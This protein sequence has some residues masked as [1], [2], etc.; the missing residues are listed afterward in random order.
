M[1]ARS[2]RDSFLSGDV[3]ASRG[4]RLSVLALPLVAFFVAASPMAASAQWSTDPALNLSVAQGAGEQILPKV[5]PTADGGCY[6]SWYDGGSGYDVRVQRLD[7]GGNPQ[8]GA[9]GVLVADR[10]FSSVQDYALDIDAAGNALLVFRDD[11][12]GG[13]Q[14]TAASIGSDGTPLWGANGIQ[15]TST[16]DFVAAPKIA[17]TTDGGAVVAWT[18]D[19]TTRVQ[20]LDSIGGTVWGADVVLTP[21]AGSYSASD[22]HGAGDGAILSFVHQTGGF[23][24]PRHIIAQKFDG[25][26]G[27]LWGAGH[28]SVFDSGSVQFGN[29]PTFVTDGSGGAVFSW[30]DAGS[31]QLQCGVQRVLADGTE[32]FPHNG[33]VV[34]TVASRV[35]VN[36]SAAFA[37]GSEEIFVFWKEQTSNQAQ[38]GVFGQK[39]DA[40]GTR[41]WT[42]NGVQVLGLSTSDVGSIETW[43]VGSGAMVFWDQAPAF[44]Q[45]RLYGARLSGDGVIDVPPFDVASTP[46]GKSRLQVRGSTSGFAI[47]AW[48]DQRVD[49]GDVY[50]QSVQPDGSLGVDPTSAPEVGLSAG[51]SFASPNPSRGEVMVSFAAVAGSG[52]AGAA[53]GSSAARTAAVFD[54]HGRSVRGGLTVSDRGESIWDGRDGAGRE[55]VPGVYY[56]RVVDGAEAV[57]VTIVR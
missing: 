1:S 12:F 16:S 9:N 47:L 48:Q 32:A 27:L 46:S 34:S 13:T 41:Q 28:V 43:V 54:V 25:A 4:H 20:K 42:D 57:A 40:S 35:R 56:V 44:N 23:G 26:G 11:R 24:S 7:A 31:S 10:S 18:Q 45:D 51:R 30:Y 52:T 3:C 8:L 53:F 29:F 17:G 14:I 55:V 38:S 5:A 21:G 33:V 6:L 37:P 2:T 50:A 15:L 39:I 36:P 49:S 22:L 19:V